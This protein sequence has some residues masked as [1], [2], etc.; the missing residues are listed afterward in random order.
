MLLAAQLITT[1]AL[2]RAES[3]GGHYR[4]DYPDRDAALDGVHSL[5]RAHTIAALR[6]VKRR[7][8]MSDNTSSSFRQS[9]PAPGRRMAARP[10]QTAA[11]DPLFDSDLIRRALAEDVGRGDVTTEATIPPGDSQQRPNRRARGWRHRRAA[12]RR[13][14]LRPARSAVSSSR[15]SARW[16]QRSRPARRWRG[17]RVTQRRC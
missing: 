3:R 10:E 16:R 13:A 17:S 8:P 9:P 11:F 1:A 15:R 12:H 4:E 2:A 5:M 7:W 6:E 14:H